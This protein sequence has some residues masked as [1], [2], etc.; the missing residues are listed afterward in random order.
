MARKS[1]KMI[2]PNMKSI[3]FNN[4]NIILETVSVITTDNNIKRSVY[5]KRD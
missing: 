1:V 5:I 2:D 3:Y 4:L